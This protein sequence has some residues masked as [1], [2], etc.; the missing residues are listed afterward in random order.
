MDSYLR[1]LVVREQT[2][3]GKAFQTVQ[4]YIGEAQEKLSMSYM[5]LDDVTTKDWARYH[6]LAATEG[7]WHHLFTGVQNGT[8]DHAN[9]DKNLGVTAIIGALKDELNDISDETEGKFV[10]I[11]NTEEK[12]IKGQFVGVK[13]A[14]QQGQE[15][16]AE[17]FEEATDFVKGTTEPTPTDVQGTVSSIYSAASVTAESAYSAASVTAD[18]AVS[19][20]ADNAESAYSVVADS[21]DSAYSAV[22][23][24]A[25]KVFSDLSAVLLPTKVAKALDDA[26]SSLSAGLGVASQSLLSL[27]GAQPSP[28][29]ASQSAS[30]LLAQATSYLVEV[31]D[32]AESLFASYAVEATKSARS[33]AGQSIE[34]TDLAGTA[35]SA[36][37]VASE[38]AASLA[39]RMASEI[40]FAAGNAQGLIEQIASDA[41]AALP[42]LP[43]TSDIPAYTDVSSTLASQ[44][45][46]ATR[47]A[48][49]LAGISVSPEGVAERASSI[50]NQ[51]SSV[52][53]SALDEASSQIHTATRTMAKAVGVTPTPENV[54]EYV[55]SVASGASEAFDKAT[56]AVR[57]HIE[58]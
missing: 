49:H 1:T 38:S 23:D 44:L 41:Y 34:P 3:V 12:R 24:S 50:Y 52:A 19:A 55:E 37:S 36:Y 4:N 57:E 5:W 7:S 33:V 14:V 28:T 8:V 31:R 51:A 48:A 21:A 32:S 35:S 16:L 54:A 30:S 53:A 11:Q 15:K 9:L 17:I 22:T 39:D 2:S 26:Q 58:L 43:G 6:S 40:A 18:S 25:E 45:H 20:V 47:E 13:D 27:A 10:S 56:A 46:Q 42:T 29:D